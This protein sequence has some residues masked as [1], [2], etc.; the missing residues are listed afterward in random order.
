MWQVEVLILT[1]YFM[2]A[3]RGRWLGF[4]RARSSLMMVLGLNTTKTTRRWLLL[5]LRGMQWM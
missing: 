4:R 5:L 3:I 2:R 1:S